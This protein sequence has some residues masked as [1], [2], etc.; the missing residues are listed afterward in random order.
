VQNEIYRQ[1][2]ANNARM[3]G[4]RQAAPAPAAVGDH[5]SVPQQIEKLD[6]LRQRGV[7][8]DAEFA[9]KKAELLRRM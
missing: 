9:E 5:L 3:Y 6:E 8:T 4:G 7:L 1:M 2:E